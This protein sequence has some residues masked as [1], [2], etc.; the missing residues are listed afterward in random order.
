ML[1]QGLLCCGLMLIGMLAQAQEQGLV[2][3]WSFDEGKGEAVADASGQ[4][5]GGTLHGP[6]FIKRGA[7]Y[8]LSFDGAND[9]VDCGAGESLNLGGGATLEAWIRPLGLPTSEPMILG[10]YYD[11]FAL[12]QYNDGNTWFY[13][14]GGGNNIKAKLPIGEWSHV[15][16]TFDGDMMLL[17]VN[18]RKVDWK[19]SPAAKANPGKTFLM[20]VLMAD[21][22]AKDPGYGGTSFWRGELDDVRV[23]SRALTE[24]ELR[25]RYKQ[26]AAG[27]GVQAQ[28][29]DRL[30]LVLYPFA[31]EDKLVVLADYDGVFPRP[32][33]AV[34]KLS[35]KTAAAE[36]PAP[37]SQEFKS[38]PSAGRL[39]A[40][41]PLKGLKPGQYVLSGE[42][43]GT[44][45]KVE[46]KGEFAYPLVQAPV[47]SPAAQKVPA[48]A[49]EPPPTKFRLSVQPG[50]GFTIVANGRRLPFVSSFSY[51]S[52]GQNR[53][54]PGPADDQGEAAWKVSTRK[55]SGGYQITAGGKHYTLQ[56][57]I[58]LYPNRVNV[59]ET[60]TN[61]SA[62]DLGLLIDTYLDA[63]DSPYTSRNVAGYPEAVEKKQPSSPSTFVAWQDLGVGVLP[64]D[65]VAIVHD[66]L[67]ARDNH[68]GMSDDRFALAAGQSYT[69][70][71]AIYPQTSPD[72]YDFINQVRKDEGRYQT[73]EGGFGFVDRNGITKEY[74][75]LRN[76]LYA[77]FGCI[78]NVADDPEIEIEGID[79]LWLPKERARIR[80]Q[81]NNV[82]KVNPDLKLMFHNAHSLISTN[83][84]AE[85]FPDSRV[86]DASG[87]HVVYPYNYGNGAYFS[88]RRHQEGWR[89]YIYYPTPGNS[90]HDALMKSV[91]S[92]V[93]D[94]GCNGAFMD[95]FFWA[96]GSPWTYDRWDGHTAEIDPETKTIKRKY[97]S[98]LLLSQPSMI[99]FTKRMHD[100]GAVVIANNTIMTRAMGKL[101]MI[102]DQELRSGPDVH[103]A[104]TPCALGNAVTIRDEA[105]VYDDVLDKLK[106]GNLY[107]YYGEKA[108]TYPSLPQQQFPI[109]VEKLHEG[110][111]TGRERLITMKPGV[112][113]WRDN[114]DLHQCYRYNS[115]GV[116]IPAEFLTTVDKTG[117]R[118]NVSLDKRESAV[119]KRIPVTLETTGPVNVRVERHDAEA[120]E[121]TLNGTGAV[122][123]VL[124]DLK[125]GQPV[126]VEGVSAKLAAGKDGAVRIPLK[127]SGQRN[128]VVRKGKDGQH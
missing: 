27:Y 98:V 92:M 64:L 68:A 9:Y 99:E 45:L 24:A 8:A 73:V 65:D 31:A 89:W 15:V 37:P 87:T 97:S 52:G 90:F 75:D 63:A 77:S 26:T 57:V 126:T 54:L 23:Y 84:P 47:P 111:I 66:V 29:F 79:F 113:G 56:R 20:G 83:K 124:R 46:A 19:K 36:A 48:L 12:T 3:S 71:W 17:Y 112:Y 21:P 91:D 43:A 121:L 118:T 55:L 82:R 110:V 32:A 117:V 72:Y 42:L 93:D 35:V 107:F 95:G 80:E 101:P 34:L 103:L 81:F 76:L 86:I 28:W 51:P 41:F 1:R 44:G 125:P 69:L 6:T 122:T 62:D 11:S 96:Y 120:L 119:V 115:V 123:L 108:L 106:W 127:L 88:D 39:A 102:V 18:R 61:T 38:L 13:I 7:G 25:G 78:C 67:Y 30:R 49:A 109:T 128:V 40:T 22:D 105:D 60:I 10:K 100:K 33:D 5:N 14:S 70:E 50:G 116:E 58:R 2:G 85:M 4:G 16:A 114:R 104:Q 59:Q 74:A 53:L 94:I